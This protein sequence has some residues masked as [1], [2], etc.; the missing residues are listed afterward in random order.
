MRPT[1]TYVQPT[2]FPVD[3]ILPLNESRTARCS[4]CTLI[5]LSSKKI[6]A[7]DRA[8]G[9]SPQCNVQQYVER[10][11]QRRGHHLRRT[12]QTQ[13]KIRWKLFQSKDMVEI[14]RG[15]ISPAP[16]TGASGQYDF[17]LTASFP[18]NECSQFWPNEC[19]IRLSQ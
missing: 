18:P 7:P 12:N 6:S 1:T 4:C 10:Y 11:V 3:H 15:F 16:G 2:H 13:I 17:H 14:G 19:K 5:S 9:S 8:A